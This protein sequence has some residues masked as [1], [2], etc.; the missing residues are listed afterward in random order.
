MS[1][2]EHLIELFPVVMSVKAA[3]APE[4]NH[5]LRNPS[6]GRPAAANLSFSSA[7]MLATV[8]LAAL[9]PWIP[10]RPLAS[11]RKSSALAAISGKPRPLALNRP[12]FGPVDPYAARYA[13]TASS[14]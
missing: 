7:M 3:R 5:G 2:C 8:G 11:M 13:D 1:F 6:G 4:Y 10:E 14:W 9:V 12:T